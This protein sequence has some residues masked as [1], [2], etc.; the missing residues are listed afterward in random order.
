MSGRDLFLLFLS[1]QLLGCA[2]PKYIN[3][4]AELQIQGKINFDCSVQ[5]KSGLCA[6][7]VWDHFPKENQFGSFFIKIYRLNLG[8]GSPVPVEVES[9]VKAVLWMP[10]MGHGSSPITVTQVDVGTYKAERVF[11][12]MP[13]EWEIKI[14]QKQGD[15]LLDEAV[16]N[17]NF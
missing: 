8:D 16:F 6:A 12:V 3:A 2:R 14:Q 9:S 7:I 15:T 4:T 1:F 13:G 5:F 10:S 11:F 17:L